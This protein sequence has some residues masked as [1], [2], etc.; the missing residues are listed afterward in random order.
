MGLILFVPGKRAWK[1]KGS[2]AFTS[3]IAVRFCMIHWWKFSESNGGHF[4]TGQRGWPRTWF[5][6]PVFA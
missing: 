5:F 4:K 2:K 3:G 1:R 6:Y